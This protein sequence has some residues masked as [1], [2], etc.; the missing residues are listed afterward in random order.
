MLPVGS[1][2]KSSTCAVLSSNC[3]IWHGAAIPCL[4][5][6]KDDT[7]TDVILK[8][9]ELL[10]DTQTTAGSVNVDTTPLGNPTTW[11]TYNDV[12]QFV[13]NDLSDLTTIVNNI[14]VPPTPNLT[15]DVA[16]CLQVAAGGATLGVVDYT[17]LL[18]TEVCAL[19][20]TV[21]SLETDVTTNTNNIV[22]INN[23]L[24]SLSTTYAPLNSSYVCLS[25]GVD[26]LANIVSTIEQA[27][28][29][30][31]A[32][33]GNPAELGA[34]IAPYCN[35]SNSD[36]LSAPGTM[37]SAYPEW[38]TT[39]STLG[40]TIKNLWITV[41]DMRTRLVNLADCCT[42]TC[43]DIR[44]G[45][46][47]EL[48]TNILTV[49]T[50]TGSELPSDFTQCLVPGST[51]TITDGDGTSYTTV[52]NNIETLIAGGSQAI[53]LSLTGLN[54]ATDFS[55]DVAYCFS[56]NTTGLQCQNVVSFNII[57]TVSCP[58]LTLASTWNNV[59]G[60]GTVDYSFNNLYVASSLTK[61]RITIYDASLAVVGTVTTAVAST[62]ANPV[63]GSFI[64]SNTGDY[65]VEIKIIT[66][67]PGT[68]VE[69]ISKTCPALPVTVQNSTCLPP[70]NLF[71]VNIT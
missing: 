4:N 59:A 35:I 26:T 28:C 36:A 23:V 32:Q 66:V 64:V 39:V 24:S 55:A 6:C 62:L 18:G 31:E 34:N 61:Y 20:T 51:I 47:A 71:A 45:F 3:V 49:R 53:D 30:L 7:I 46:R 60:T 65:T 70:T 33:T 41:C 58:T 68:G 27:V 10:C 48:N 40:E 15:A 1:N 42:S 5:L 16:A 29:D 44:L 12:I 38:N 14:V 2:H 19:K 37:A 57:N 54:L 52:F 21:G 67:N 8:M 43:A 22:V 25:S 11:T 63:T 69:T 9:G 17:E 56:N 13:V 50:T